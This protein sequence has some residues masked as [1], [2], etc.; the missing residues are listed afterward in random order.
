MHDIEGLR[1]HFRRV[2]ELERASTAR[3]PASVMSN[4]SLQ[5]SLI[6]RRDFVNL[7]KLFRDL[8]FE[9]SRLRF[10]VNR[11]QLD[12]TLATDMRALDVENILQAEPSVQQPASTSAGGGGLVARLLSVGGAPG[13]EAEHHSLRRS[14]TNR[15]SMRPIGL[16]SSAT[17][18]VAFESGVGRAVEASEGPASVA[19]GSLSATAVLP[20][21]SARRKVGAK[22]KRELNSIFAGALPLKAPA[23]STTSAHPVP[24]RVSL[25]PFSRLLAYRPALSA[26]TNAILDSFQHSPLSSG[27]QAPVPNLLERQ[28]RP[29]GLSDSSIRSTFV[30]HANPHHRIISPATL[31][32]SSEVSTAGAIPILYQNL[33]QDSSQQLMSDLRTGTTPASGSLGRKASAGILRSRPSIVQLRASSPA[34]QDIPPVPA[35]PVSLP[36]PISISLSISPSRQQKPSPTVIPTH[37]G[38][39]DTALASS[40]AQTGGGGGG[41]MFE[42]LSSW[43][44]MATALSPLAR[45]VQAEDGAG[46]VVDRSQSK[47]RLSQ[48]QDRR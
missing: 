22:S 44:S 28:L 26:T 25:N 21:Q 34:P 39:L 17:I 1:P 32:L 14:V 35:L 47:S 7:V 33:D 12:P 3:E 48:V 24:T 41:G 11:V 18:N 6:V 15:S 8:L 29:R 36:A 5:D 4:A 10:I 30:A 27:D 20:A 46:L 38:P 42:S 19:G 31:A 13:P 45:A 43:A 2:L 37:P 40:L 23:S 16:V 9:T